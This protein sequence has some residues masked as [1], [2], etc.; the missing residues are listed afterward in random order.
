MR[1]PLI[2]KLVIFIVAIVLF[3]A[4]GAAYGAEDKEAAM[5]GQTVAV[6]NDVEITAQEL[7]QK[8][9]LIRSR[10]A[11]MGMPIQGEQLV[12]LRD[13][14]LNN[15]IEKQLL[16]EE[17]K[18]QD[19]NVDESEIQEQLN[20]LK[21]QFESQDAFEKKIASSGYSEDELKTE[22]REN[23][24]IRNLIEKKIESGISVSDEQARKYYQENKEEYKVPEQIRARHILIQT[25]PDADEKQKAEAKDKIQEVEKKLQSG[26]EFSELAKEYSDCQSS[27]KGGDLGYFRRGQMVESFDEAAFALEPGE[28][29]E[30]VESRFGY[31]LIKSEDKK[32]ADT[33]SFD[34]VKESVREKLRQEKI[35]QDLEPYIES[36][37]RKYPV[38]KNLPETS[39][40]N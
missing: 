7:E 1:L 9:Q 31:H 13:S 3:A 4:A 38:E 20:E 35:M 30:I 36:L 24:L 19:I 28:V 5:D 22:M 16:I 39:A 25:E 8:M 26:Q 21:G 12:Q 2:S 17:S 27:E 18:A 37:K 33:K 40:G 6:V 15:L 34:E 10:Y 14:I 32:P 23:L 29:S 11:N